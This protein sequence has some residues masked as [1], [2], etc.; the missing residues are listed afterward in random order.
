M[1][2]FNESV[3]KEKF[4]ARIFSTDNAEWSFQNLWKMI[5]ADVKAHKNIKKKEIKDPEPVSYKFL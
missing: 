5:S 2:S 3:K 4:V 1:G